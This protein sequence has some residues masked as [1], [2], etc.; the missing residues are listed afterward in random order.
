MHTAGEENVPELIKFSSI[1]AGPF[2]LEQKKY[3]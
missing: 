1:G 3:K 2:F